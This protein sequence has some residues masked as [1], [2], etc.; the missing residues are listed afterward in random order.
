MGK[1]THFICYFFSILF[2]AIESQ[3]HNSERTSQYTSNSVK[4]LEMQQVGSVYDLRAR[5]GR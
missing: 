5:V 2:Q 4:T 1:Y 3:L